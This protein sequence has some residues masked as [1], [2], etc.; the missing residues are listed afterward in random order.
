M[1]ADKQNGEQHQ[2][3]EQ[4]E[5]VKWINYPTPELVEDVNFTPIPPPKN[6]VI[7]GYALQIGA[8][9]ICALP[10][11][12]TFLY[13]NTSFGSTLASIP[14]ID[15][16][17][18]TFYPAVIPSPASFSSSTPTTSSPLPF[19][20][21]DLR[22]APAVDPTT[23]YWSVGDYHAAYVSGCLTPSA[24]VEFLL[25]QVDR[26]ASAHRSTHAVAFV[27]TRADLARA[28]AAA[29]TERFR[30]GK[31]RGVLDGVPVAVKDQVDIRGYG[32]TMGTARDW[33]NGGKGGEKGDEGETSWC[34]RMWEEAGAVVVGKTNMHEI[35]LDTTNNN[36]NLGT[37]RN[38][39][40]P[41]YYT[42]GSSGGSGYAVA[43]GLVPIALGCDG[44]GST[45]IPAAY[46]SQFGLKPTHGRVS[47]SPSV[48][49]AYS[50]SVS[51]PLAANM[52][53][54][55]AAWRV[56]CT[57]DPGEAV[58]ELFRAPRRPS[59]SA[60]E[61]R[62]KLLGVFRDWVDR[63][64]PPVRKLFDAALAHFTT[65]LGYAVVDVGIP[66]VPEGQ[67]AHALTILSEV[68]SVWAAPDRA[69][70]LAPAGRVLVAVGARIP[71]RDFA[72]AQKL[73]TRLMRHLAAL[74]ARHPGLVIVTPTTPNAGCH[75][76]GG[77]A[78]L[79]R[80]VSNGN[81]SVRSMEFTW[82]AN[83]LGLP[84]LNVPMG[85]VEP[86]GGEGG[87][88]PVGL[89]GMSEWGKDDELIEWGFDGERFL[90]DGLEGGRKRPEGWVDVLGLAGEKMRE[91]VSGE[92]Q[93]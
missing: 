60:G 69:P 14:G 79:R 44:G 52:T 88:V 11:I 4:E 84:G 82:M 61:A 35:G 47:I 34:V 75:I 41:N 54:L 40:N 55:E 5:D 67:A 23:R 80:G 66:L 71:A 93:G 83:L 17:P 13:N 57:P 62:P 15:A 50:T 18:P 16:L 58:S 43:T 31:A 10:P 86:V 85:Y 36:P 37:P 45:R 74:F 6:P 1:A 48:S 33:C 91:S 21:A 19:A 29:S 68:S 32:T 70:V 39:F 28:A 7:R 87:E 38:P 59:P 81:A 46:C 9:V 27:Q 92:S 64:D 12:Q 63:A 89:M 42:G 65:R 72:R 3:Q 8:S 51:G 73:R 77:E 22:P 78:D 49:L 53:D 30:A 20:A 90:H 26:S 76:A 24:V 2:Q 25:P 56:M